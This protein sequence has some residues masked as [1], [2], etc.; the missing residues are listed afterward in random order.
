M[1]R[2][3]LALGLG[4]P[5]EA[6]AELARVP[7][8][9]YMAARARLLAGQIELRRDRF[10]FAEEALREAVR[11]DPKL[12]QA[13]RER[14]NIYGYQLRRPELAGEFLALSRLTKLGFDELVHWGLMQGE[15]WE[16]TGAAQVLERCVAADPADRW[17]RLALSEIKRKAGAVDEAE[18]ALAG[19]AP[20]DPAAIAA[21]TRIAL[22]RN[23]RGRAGRLLA[24]GPPGDPTLARLRGRVALSEGHARAALNHF[25]VAFEAQP[26]VHEV[27]TGLIAALTIL[28]DA[29][30]LEPLR[31]LAARRDRLDRLIQRAAS[32]VSREDRDLSL[33]LGDACSDLH[34]DAEA[35]GWY[36]LAIARDPLDSR[37]QRALF[38]M[39]TA[40]RDGPLTQR[41][42]P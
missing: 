32:R 23:D 41:P 16:P 5:D 9:H 27:V 28:G 6:L 42:G 30:A 21:R 11:L 13:H 40:A 19:L 38:Q 24:S 1:L 29:E 17:S 39:G 36:K 3:Q 4:R 33:R 35:R 31:N 20:D 7:D 37:A 26:D 14:I 10:R 22:D 25:Q 15:T 34:R 12:V 2:G 18:D 8:E